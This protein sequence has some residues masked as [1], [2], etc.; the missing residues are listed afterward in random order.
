MAKYFE[1]LFDI[2][3]L[4]SINIMGYLLI[5]RSKD[6]EHFLFGIMA[7]MLGLGDAF[8]LIPRIFATYYGDFETFSFFL[9]YGEMIT[10]I[11]MTFFYLI[12]YKIY[13]LRYQKTENK[14]LDFT[15]I[16][17]AII[18][19]ILSLLPN[20][21]WAN[22]EKPYSWIIIRN[23]PFVIIGII[24]ISLFV[25]THKY[26]E[27]DMYSN[28]SIAILLSFGFYIP[29]ILGA[30]FYPLLGLLMIPKTLAYVWI[31]IL[32]IKDNKKLALDN[33]I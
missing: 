30:S 16:I 33:S 4:I 2:T 23:I 3:Y 17:L 9:G 21:N 27:H 10:S 1:I 28:M 31:I 25:R 32:G 26:K 20:N 29:V 24:M 5:K 15:L 22:L 12:L 7:L 11:T 14:P 19:I 8:H 13:K 18:R 6:K